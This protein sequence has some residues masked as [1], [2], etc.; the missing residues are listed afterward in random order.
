MSPKGTIQCLRL[1]LS[2]EISEIWPNNPRSDVSGEDEGGPTKMII[3]L[4]K[5]GKINIRIKTQDTGIK[6]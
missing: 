4:C 2:Y 3:Q 6:V 5:V 1:Q